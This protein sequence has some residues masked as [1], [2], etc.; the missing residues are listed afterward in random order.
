MYPCLILK[1]NLKGKDMEVLATEKQ[2]MSRAVNYLKRFK[3]M[4]KAF[5]TGNIKKL[6]ML[7]N[8]NDKDENAQINPG[9][10]ETQELVCLYTD[11]VLA[12]PSVSLTFR[13]GYAGLSGSEKALTLRKSRR[14][15]CDRS[16]VSRR[17]IQFSSNQGIQLRETR[18]PCR[19]SCP[20]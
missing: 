14:K 19:K 15:T 9:K 1:E 11:Y 5:A 3:T 8:S 13:F 17:A 16:H 2:E 6:P 4:S 7:E 12:S 18:S 20:A 10:D